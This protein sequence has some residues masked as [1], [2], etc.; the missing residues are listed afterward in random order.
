MSEWKT[1][2]SAP[3][4]GTRVRLRNEISGETDEG[5]WS[6]WEDM[7]A[8][9]RALLPEWA[10]DWDGEWSTVFGKGEMTHWDSLPAPPES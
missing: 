4:D 8:S 1:I 5:F 7:P 10:R 3:K 2:D 6:S 9:H